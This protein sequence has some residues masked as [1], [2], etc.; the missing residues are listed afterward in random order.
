MTVVKIWIMDKNGLRVTRGN[1]TIMIRSANNQNKDEIK[2][3]TSNKIFK[4][5]TVL[6]LAE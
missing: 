1:K 3:S 6:R 4:S 5:S 2:W